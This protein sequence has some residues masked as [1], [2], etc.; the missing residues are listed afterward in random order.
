MRCLVTGG[1][2]YIGAHVVAALLERSEEVAV[3]DDLS[4]GVASRVGSAQLFVGDIT[5]RAW[6]RRTL[7]EF[8]PDVVAMVSGSSSWRHIVAMPDASVRP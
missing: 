1:A 8:R 5:D 3:L 4:T 6:T 7:L 2:G